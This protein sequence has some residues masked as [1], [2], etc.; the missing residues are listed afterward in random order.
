MSVCVGKENWESHAGVIQWWDVYADQEQ[1]S[2]KHDLACGRLDTRPIIKDM[3]IVEAVKY[4]APN[5][6]RCQTP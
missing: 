5:T 4:P 3:Q 1:C 2:G 6:I